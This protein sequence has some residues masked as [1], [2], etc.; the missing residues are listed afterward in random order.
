M[1]TD[2]GDLA[3]KLPSSGHPKSGRE[4]VYPLYSPVWKALLTASTYSGVGFEVTKRWMMR[5]EMKIGVFLGCE[6][7]DA[8]QCQAGLYCIVHRIGTGQLIWFGT[9]NAFQRRADHDNCTF[10]REATT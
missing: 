5:Y 1:Q 8:R 7:H 2:L 10:N 9:G 3:R 4:H 6:L